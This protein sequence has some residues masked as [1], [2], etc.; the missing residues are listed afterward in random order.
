MV[1]AQVRDN[2]QVNRTIIKGTVDDGVVFIVSNAEFTIDTTD[3]ANAITGF[4]VVRQGL[5]LRNTTSSTDG[6]TSSHMVPWYSDKR[7]KTRRSCG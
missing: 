6:I 1:T 7:R 3:P 5:T 2:N 4:D